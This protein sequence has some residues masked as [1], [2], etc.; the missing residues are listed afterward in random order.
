MNMQRNQFRRSHRAFTL[1][2]LLVVIAIIAILAAMLLPAIS[3]MKESARKTKAKLEIGK[4]AQGVT[5]YDSA[6]SRPPILAS[7]SSLGKP[8]FTFGCR[9]NNFSVPYEPSLY[10]VVPA[11]VYENNQLVAIL[12]DLTQFGNG[13]TTS[14][15]NHIKNTQQTKFLNT[16]VVSDDVSAGIGSDGVMRDPWGNPYIVSLDVDG[17][18]KTMDAFYGK[19]DV[20]QKNGQTGINGLFNSKSATGNTDQFEFR[21]PVMAWSAGPD[22]KINVATP[23]DQGDNKDNILSWKP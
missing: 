9:S 19:K 1:I 13:V 12:A 17:D 3:K 6:Y 10:P 18:D 15:L 8:D 20:S 22:K 2:E 5:A 11:N 7:Y 14:N 21:G 4:I 23:A 16:D